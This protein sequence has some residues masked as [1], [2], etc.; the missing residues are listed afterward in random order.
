MVNSSSPA[1]KFSEK[2]GLVIEKCIRLIVI[3]GI[4]IFI[5]GKLGGSTPS[6][7]TPAPPAP[8]P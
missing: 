8:S 7:S 6:Q 2:V 1:Y 5:G 3:G 4:A